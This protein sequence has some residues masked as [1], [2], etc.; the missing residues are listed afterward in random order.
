MLVIFA[1][2]FTTAVATDLEDH[3][4]DIGIS[5]T[6]L[7]ATIP[8]IGFNVVDIPLGPQDVIRGQGGS[9]RGAVYTADA[10]YPSWDYAVTVTLVQLSS[11]NNAVYVLVRVQDIDNMYAV[12]LR[13]VFGFGFC[14]RPARRW[15]GGEA[16]NRRRR[17]HV[18]RRRRGP[19]LHCRDGYP[20][21]LGRARPRRW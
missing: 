15:F 8:G 12:R 16:G 6:E 3:A 18:L 9:S 17:S 11:V 10:V 14:V 7:W 2:T 19:G 20:H 5:W 13:E 21:R 1:D 4:P